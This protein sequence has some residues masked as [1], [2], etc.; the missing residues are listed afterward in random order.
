MQGISHEP[1]SEELDVERVERQRE[2]MIAYKGSMNRAERRAAE[3]AARRQ[4]R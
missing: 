1:W 4:K 3:K 2:E